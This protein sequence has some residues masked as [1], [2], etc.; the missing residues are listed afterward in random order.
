MT[1]PERDSRKGWRDLYEVW[2]LGIVFPLAIGIGFFLGRWLDGRFD[3]WPWLT[4]GFTVVGAAAAFRQ[5]F[6]A[7]NPGSKSGPPGDG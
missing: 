4:I 7:G 5:L 2:T 3:T 1:E 6:R